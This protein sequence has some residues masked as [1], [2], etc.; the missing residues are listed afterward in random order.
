M[1]A[2]ELMTEKVVTIP[3]GA[4]VADASSVLVSHAITAAPVVDTDGRVVGI[5]SDGDLLRDRLLPDPRAHLRPA[6]D[7]ERPDPPRLV[8]D[9]MTTPVHTVP[10]TAAE[11][12]IL[13]MML[14]YRIK[15]LPVVDAEHRAV[16]IVSR[17][18]LLR[19]HTRSDEALARDVTARLGE[20]ATEGDRWVVEVED[21]VVTLAGPPGD[22]ARRLAVLVAASVPGV[23]RVHVRDRRTGD[24]LP[25][26]E[27][28]NAAADH[29]GIRVLSLEDCLEH[30]RHS[31]VGRIAF[32][33]DGGPII[34][35]VNHGV[36]G[37][38]VVFRTTWG[39]KLEAA[40][41]AGAAAYE[42]DGY[43]RVAHRAWSVLVTGRVEAVYEPADIARLERLG[44]RAWPGGSEPFWVRVRADEISGR[45]L[46]V[47]P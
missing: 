5:V 35:P 43:D 41:T 31:A 1:L 33:H 40:Q 4:T 7:A 42:V 20:L 30:L 32:V 2:K 45:E 6:H 39:S 26:A 22:S 8:A 15:S 18:D 24:P 23:S 44:V 13:R 29:R 28:G 47:S 11:S 38:D 3:Q 46:N 19:G 14:A 17:G 25:G 27:P 37:L 9:V 34:L 10:A 21:S 36:D 16:G 12:E